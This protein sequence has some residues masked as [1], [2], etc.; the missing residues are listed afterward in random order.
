MTKSLSKRTH[1]YAVGRKYNTIKTKLFLLSL[2]MCKMGR[3]SLKNRPENDDDDPA[4]VCKQKTCY[5]CLFSF[6][7]SH[8]FR[9]H[10]SLNIQIS[11]CVCVYNVRVKRGREQSALPRERRKH[12]HIYIHKY[13]KS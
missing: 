6:S 5:A 7:F 11:F 10:S 12:T 2:K 8:H 4:I 9:H 1:E 3:K 13:E